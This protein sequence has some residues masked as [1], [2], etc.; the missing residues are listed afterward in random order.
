MNSR[1]TEPS[2]PTIGKL[3][4]TLSQLTH[5]FLKWIRAGKTNLGLV[6]GAAIG[7]VGGLIYHSV[8]L[9]FMPYLRLSVVPFGVLG[10]TLLFTGFGAFLGFLT[11]LTEKRYKGVLIGAMGFY[12]CSLTWLFLSRYLPYS[13]MIDIGLYL[14]Y[15]GISGVFSSFY[16]IPFA[17]PVRILID[18][19]FETLNENRPIQLK[20]KHYLIALFACV[21]VGYLGF[22]PRYKREFLERVNVLVQTAEASSNIQ[23]YPHPLEH[24]WVAQSF[25]NNANGKY[26]LRV[27]GAF[28]WGAYLVNYQ[29]PVMLEIVV[30]FD[31]GW[32]L[33]CGFDYSGDI[34]YCVGSDLFT[35][36]QTSTL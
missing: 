32:Q 12:F 28:Y 33:T 4:S 8:N 18:R 6:I 10:N 36:T 34:P 21:M 15:Y 3:E 17:I 26:H 11:S 9:I 27:E 1:F 25:K 20:F 5:A 29:E 35:R 23:L 24:E 13:R 2:T 19:V 7:M 30:E 14:G 31:N 22:M 16:I